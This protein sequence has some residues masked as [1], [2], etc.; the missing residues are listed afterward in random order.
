MGVGADA[1]DSRSTFISEFRPQLK[2]LGLVVGLIAGIAMLWQGVVMFGPAW[3]IHQG[4]GVQG[5]LVIEAERCGRQCSYYGTFTSADATQRLTA[6][7]LLHGGERVGE[8]VPAVYLPSGSRPPREVHAL[9]SN[10]LLASLVLLGAGAMAALACAGIL[11]ETGVR[12]W[13]KHRSE[14]AF[15]RDWEGRV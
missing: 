3:A 12:S 1:A 9:E 15:L 11:I 6:A 4:R 8:R 13:R 10:A 7:E 2:A 14:S 5:V